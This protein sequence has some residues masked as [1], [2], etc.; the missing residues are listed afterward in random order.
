[1]REDDRA[2]LLDLRAIG[3]FVFE[4][5]RLSEKRAIRVLDVRSV[6]LRAD[7]HEPHVLRR[8]RVRVAIV[9]ELAFAL[10]ATIEARAFAAPEDDR[11][12]IHGRRIFVTKRGSMPGEGEVRLLDVLRLLDDPKI[13]L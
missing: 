6:D 11:E 8:I 9:H 5:E 7:D 13:S 3:R 10:H 1:L 2:G 12:N 4:L